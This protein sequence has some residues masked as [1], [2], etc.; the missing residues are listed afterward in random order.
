ME[1]FSSGSCNENGLSTMTRGDLGV[2][3]TSIFKDS[4]TAYTFDFDYEWN[5]LRI[6]DR[7]RYWGFSVRAHNNDI[8]QD[9]T[10]HHLIN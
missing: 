3:Y 7:T 2:F 5:I 1:R 4:N 8:V 9:Y 6:T 10:I